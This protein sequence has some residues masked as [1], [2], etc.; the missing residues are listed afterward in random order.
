MFKR[1]KKISLEA[2]INNLLSLLSCI[3]LETRP[4]N[5]IL[6]HCHLFGI[7]CIR[8]GGFIVLPLDGE[9]AAFLSPDFKNRVECMFHEHGNVWNLD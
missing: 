9:I 5:S 4:Q 6:Y 8:T 2:K 7:E 3:S 1:L